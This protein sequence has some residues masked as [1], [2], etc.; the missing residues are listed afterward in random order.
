[1]SLCASF[2]Y[3]GQ[4]LLLQPT[5]SRPRNLILLYD[6]LQRSGWTLSEE[7]IEKLSSRW[8]IS[9]CFIRDRDDIHSKT[10]KRNDDNIKLEL[11]ASKL[12]TLDNTSQ[13]YKVFQ[14]YLSHHKTW[15][16]QDTKASGVTN[17]V[18]EEWL[19]KFAPHGK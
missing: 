18:D 19:A 5:N 13:M 16:Q 12:A 11:P 15:I 14:D 2:D 17:R 1:M 8:Y 7:Q 6:Y 9:A 10:T 3:L 4:V